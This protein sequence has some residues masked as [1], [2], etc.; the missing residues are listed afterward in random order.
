MGPKVRY[1]RRACS[2]GT[3]ALQDPIPSVNHPLI[4]ELTSSSQ[5]E[6]LA[7]GPPF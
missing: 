7:A 2:E 3:A 6:N 5:G 1:L 4:A